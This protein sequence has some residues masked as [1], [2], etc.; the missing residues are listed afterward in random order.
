MNIIDNPN[1]LFCNAQETIEHIYLECP[2][3]IRL[4]QDTENWVKS[5]DYPHFKISDTEKIQL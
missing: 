1:C 3:V 2:N 4:W 5:L